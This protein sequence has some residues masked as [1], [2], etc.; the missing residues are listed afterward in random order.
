[1]KVEAGV[2]PNCSEV[3][4]RAGLSVEEA[5]ARL[6]AAGIEVVRMREQDFW[7]REI[8]PLDTGGVE[9]LLV[10][11]DNPFLPDTVGHARLR[12][13]QDRAGRAVV[14]ARLS[15]QEQLFP[16]M[17]RIEKVLGG[18]WRDGENG[19]VEEYRRWKEAHRTPRAVREFIE[20]L[21]L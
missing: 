11:A 18:R 15:S 16:T 14:V 4:L 1:M 10:D 6:R 3:V 19:S 12:L 20:K 21:T 9:E 8:V 17:L 5:L 2:C 7:G 13:L